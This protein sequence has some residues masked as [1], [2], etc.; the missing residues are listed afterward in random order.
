MHRPALQRCF[1]PYALPAAAGTSSCECP[2]EDPRCNDAPVTEYVT[3]VDSFA[4][5]TDACDLPGAIDVIVNGDDIE[6]EAPQEIQDLLAGDFEFYYF[7]ERVTDMFIGDD[8][9]IGLGATAPGLRPSAQDIKPG[10]L[11]DT[12][13]S[14]RTVFPFWSNLEFQGAGKVCIG[15]T[16]TVPRTIVVSWSNACFK[17]GC[18]SGDDLNF[19]VSFEENEDIIKFTYGTMSS[20]DPAR[21]LGSFAVSGLVG[22]TKGT[23][24]ASMCDLSGQCTDGSPCGFTQLFS[25]VS[26]EALPAQSFNPVQ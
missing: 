18:G 2:E 3:S 13:I 16:Q 5:H 7:G 4:R 8:G 9:Y 12:A 24:D 20:Q 14:P 21:A 23:C 1:R 15:V 19:S 11:D 25:L 6:V 10:P 17:S 22:N 26:Q